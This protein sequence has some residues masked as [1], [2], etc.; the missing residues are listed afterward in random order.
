MER[1]YE[2]MMI[3]KAGLPD[4]ENEEVFQKIIKRVEGLKGKV[5]FSKIWAKEKNFFYP[6][7]GSGSDRKNHF[8]GCYWIVDFK[9]DTVSLDGLKETIRLEERILRNLII[10]KDELIK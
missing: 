4:K 7:K 1:S 6:I 9:L 5:S 8:K 3:L 10:K 2:S